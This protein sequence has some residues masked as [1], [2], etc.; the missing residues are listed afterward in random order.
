MFTLVKSIL[1][2]P[3]AYPEPDRLVRINQ[4]SPFE[5]ANHPRFALAPMEFLRWR[6]EIQSCEFLALLRG[7]AVNLTGVGAPEALGAVRISAEFFDTLKIQP[8]LGR[9]FTRNEEGR[10]MP[11]VAIISAYLWRQRFSADPHVIGSKIVLNGIPH[12]V[13]GVTPPDMRFFRGHQLD[14]ENELPIAGRSG[15]RQLAPDISLQ[16]SSACG[17]S[18]VDGRG[19]AANGSGGPNWQ[20]AMDFALCGWFCTADRVRESGK[21]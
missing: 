2:K 14:L 1:L 11:D 19:T 10:G 18:L 13:V 8:V 17:L 3:L 20:A 7:A 5:T 6:K 4:N 15:T 12:E 21:P 16:S 9:G